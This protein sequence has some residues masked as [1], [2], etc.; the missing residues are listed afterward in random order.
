MQ[1]GLYIYFMTNPKS[2]CQKSR[3]TH[4]KTKRCKQ[5][6][7]SPQRAGTFHWLH[8][9]QRAGRHT[10][11]PVQKGNVLSIRCQITEVVKLPYYGDCGDTV[12]E[13]L[14]KTHS[15]EVSSY[16]AN[17]CEHDEPQEKGDCSYCQDEELPAIFT[18]EG[19]GIHVHHRCH[20]ALHT[21][22]LEISH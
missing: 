4:H 2:F 14:C 19:G 17:L 10:S 7:I 16:Q 3:H 9:N 6:Q 18:P 5:S 11:P 22:K 20:Q 13:D 1:C 8:S 12:T 15:L 21:H